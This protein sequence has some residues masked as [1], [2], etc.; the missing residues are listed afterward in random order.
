MMQRVKSDE[1][2]L[3]NII[4]E[5]IRKLRTANG[6]SINELAGLVKVTPGFL[7]LI[8]RGKRGTTISNL[9]KI[10]DMLKV[11]VDYLLQD[12]DKDTPAKLS[13]S[14][15]LLEKIHMQLKIQG[16]EELIFITNL[17]NELRKMSEAN[18]A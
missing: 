10:S 15:M 11:S 4:G 7:G 16:K 3:W 18:R 8:E 6:L 17:L 5:N 2:I 12:A 9:I 1:A 14:D 13:E